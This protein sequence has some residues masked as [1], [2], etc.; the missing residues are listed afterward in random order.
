M[1]VALASNLRQQ[2]DPARDTEI[3]E[4]EGSIDILR[5]RLFGRCVAFRTRQYEVITAAIPGPQAAA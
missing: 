1:F 3:R 5:E 2:G 4:L